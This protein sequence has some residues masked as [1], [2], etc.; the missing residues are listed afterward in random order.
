MKNL[1]KKAAV[2]GDIHYGLKN[3]AKS[4]NDDCDEYIDWFCKVAISEGCDVCIFLGDLYHTRNSV[5][6]STLNYGYAGL[7]KISKSF[8]K[9]Y[10]ILGNHDIY[11]REKRDLYSYPFANQF[12]NITVITDITTVGNVSLVPWLVEDEWKSIGNIDSKYIFGHFELPY[13]KM[14]EMVEMPDH[15]GLKKE[16]F[17]K[18]EY[19]FSGHFHKRQNN[20]KIHYVGSPFAHNYADVWDDERG[21]MILEWGTTPRYIDWANGPRYITIALSQLLENPDEYLSEKLYCK[22][23][24]DIPVSYEE[25]NFI[26][27]TFASQY[28]LRELSLI[29]QKTDE[30]AIDWDSKNNNLVIENV[31]QIVV[32]QL[33]S[34]DSE[35]INKDKLM[36]IYRNL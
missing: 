13:F 19:V 27:E 18:P 26:K 21:M 32:S 12:E 36:E 5:N 30:H 2:F 11:F 22:V 1:F 16:D 33:S 4:H 7:E 3:N 9:V 28:K 20:G 23:I 6:V 31:D 24:L 29:P 15:G 34:V 25:A 35:F 8:S 10:L 17:T 14:N